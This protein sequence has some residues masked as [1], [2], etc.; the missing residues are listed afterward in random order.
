MGKKTDYDSLKQG[1]GLVH[2]LS[3]EFVRMC[4]RHHVPIEAIHRLVTPEGERTMEAIIGRINADWRS[5]Q[6]ASTH[7][8]GLLL[9]EYRVYVGY[10]M[11]RDNAKLEPWFSQDLV[12]DMLRHG[13]SYPHS[14]CT[15]IDQ[16][17]GERI[18]LV[19]CFD[20]KTQSEANI[21]EMDGLGY[22]PATLEEM[23]AFIKGS[24]KLWS[25]FRIIGL[26]VYVEV[27]GETWVPELSSGPDG[28]PLFTARNFEEMW[29]TS[30]RFL[31][32]RK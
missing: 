8:S 1:F 28:H 27:A 7:E 26:G 21:F 12:T 23:Y 6:G 32:F 2:G 29:S 5:S 22:R 16:T 9:D 3:T 4:E 20:R 19:K 13:Q 18:A 30:T 25:Q 11:W 14:S 10:D 31:F 17:P 15:A 24:S